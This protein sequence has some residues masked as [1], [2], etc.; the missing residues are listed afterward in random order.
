M[1]SVDEE[2]FK[3]Q[4]S[5]E[6]WMA[7]AMA[8]ESAEIEA[9]RKSGEFYSQNRDLE[10]KIWREVATWLGVTSLHYRINQ[11]KYEKQHSGGL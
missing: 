5:Y 8:L 3:R 10:A 1:W 9:K 11:K 4:L 2:D 6:H 7:R